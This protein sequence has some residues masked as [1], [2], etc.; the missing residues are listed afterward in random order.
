MFVSRVVYDV[1][2][3]QILGFS[4]PPSLDIYRL[5]GIPKRSSW[6]RRQ[7]QIFE[8]G[9]KRPDIWYLAGA[10]AMV[11]GEEVC[12]ELDEDF[13]ASELLPLIITDENL[14]V[15]AVNV[16]VLVDCL[17]EESIIE[18][19][20]RLVLDFVPERLPADGLFK[21]P[22]LAVTETFVVER[23]ERHDSFR[24]RLRRHNYQGIRLDPVWS[25]DG[26][27][28]ETRLFPVEV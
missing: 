22:E 20:D 10:F 18:H 2:A 12:S 28:I 3:Y 9:L 11:V 16:L 13:Q 4:D 17:R 27:A 14:E 23:A 7:V 5:E 15:N 25:S 19:G 6:H 8:K 21:V 1:E 24:A 26:G